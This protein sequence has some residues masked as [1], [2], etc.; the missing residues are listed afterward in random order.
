MFELEL[1][2]LVEIGGAAHTAA[3]DNNDSFTDAV[4]KFVLRN[5]Q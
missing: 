3:G 4:A 2:E 5:E 1:A